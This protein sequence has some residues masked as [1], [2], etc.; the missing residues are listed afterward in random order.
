MPG[1]SDVRHC[2]LF[3]RALTLAAFVLALAAPAWARHLSVHLQTS[4]PRKIVIAENGGGGA[5]VATRDNPDFAEAFTLIDINAGELM[6]GDAVIFR[7]PSG[8]FLVAEGGGG[9]ELLANRTS[10]AEWETFTIVLAS[11]A[12]GRI[13]DGANVHIRAR[14]GHF[15]VAEGGGGGVVNANRSAAS[16]WET[17]TLIVNE[18]AP[19]PV[20]LSGPFNLPQAILPNPVGVDFTPL[21]NSNVL[22][23]TNPFLG[24]N[25]PNCYSGHTGSDLLLVGG[26]A[27][28]N[29]GSIEVTAAASGYVVGIEKDRYD[30][31]HFVPAPPDAPNKQFVV[32][33]GAPA[34]ELLANYVAVL[35][36]DGLVAYYF[37]L[38]QGSI[39]VQLSQRVSCGQLLGRVGSSGVSSTPHL[40]FEL[41]DLKCVRAFPNVGSFGGRPGVT[42]DPYSL[43]LWR[44]M[45]PGAGA[46]IPKKVCSHPSAPSNIPRNNGQPCSGLEICQPPN[47]CDG[48]ICRMLNLPPAAACD[49]NHLCQPTLTCQR[50]FCAAAPQLSLVGGDCSRGQG[51]IPGAECR[52]GVCREV[53]VP[54]NGICDTN[55][56]CRS[57]L[58]CL[59][60]FCALPPPVGL[61]GD[62]SRGETCEP[63]LLCRDARCQRFGVPAAGVCDRNQNC[64]AGLACLRGFCAVPQ[65]VGRGGDCSG[66]QACEL[67][68]SCHDGRCKLLNVGPGGECDGTRL[69]G[70]RLTCRRG[71]CAL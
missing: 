17:F 34:G 52:G 11:G 46:R 26:F 38:Q 35:Q 36:D 30:R 49:A 53:N 23:C 29:A 13:D 9:L 68:L 66:G 56:I 8:H 31:C 70:S 18:A 55:R 64:A 37:H 43:N 12:S 21:P 15:L 16:S 7:T 27:A 32:C 65:P 45:W 47:A 59:R 33:P 48:G 28:M 3:L 10:P 4:G 58:L 6:S 60:G 5:V 39:P 62:C 67:G 50:G 22:F 61:G 40:H 1:E 42:V 57:E 25:F 63:G 19:P 44:E 20:K 51:C 24:L 2:A 71:R 54:L 14:S 41:R 69:C